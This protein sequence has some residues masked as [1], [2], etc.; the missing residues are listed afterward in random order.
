V[1]EEKSRL[2]PSRDKDDVSY[3]RPLKA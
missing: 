2:S 1:K 3:L